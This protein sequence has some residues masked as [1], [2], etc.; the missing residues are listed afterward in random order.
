MASRASRPLEAIFTVY[1]CRSSVELTIERTCISSSTTRTRAG[2]RAPSAGA[3]SA[4]S[5]QAAPTIGNRCPDRLNPIALPLLAAGA[6][7][8]RLH[9]HQL[10]GT[11]PTASLKLSTHLAARQ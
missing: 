3:A 4:L 8:T 9:L 5:R 7:R 10:K 11:D 1:P 6:S 2:L